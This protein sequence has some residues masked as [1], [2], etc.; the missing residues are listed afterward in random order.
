[1]SVLCVFFSQFHTKKGNQIDYQIPK[2]YIKKEDFD[3]ISE[4]ILPKIELCNKIISMKLGNAYLMGLPINISSPKYFRAKYQFNFCILITS[5]EYIKYREQY[6]NLLKIITKTYEE[7][8]TL[9]G[10]GLMIN[11]K[12][13]IFK[14]TKKLF[15]QLLN[16]AKIINIPIKLKILINKDE[17]KL[18]LEKFNDGHL[19]QDNNNDEENDK[20]TDDNI[21]SIKSVQNNDI[22]FKDNSLDKIDIKDINENKIK[23]NKNQYDNNN[24]QIDSNLMVENSKSRINPILM[25]NEKNIKNSD[26]DIDK[27]NE[28]NNENFQQDIITNNVLSKNELKEEN[29]IKDYN[30]K[31]SNCNN[32]TNKIL[33]NL[34]DYNPKSIKLI[35]QDY[36][37]D[38]LLYHNSDSIEVDFRFNMFKNISNKFIEIKD[39]Y[40][41]VFI[42]KIDEDSLKSLDPLTHMIYNTIDSESFVKKILIKIDIDLEYIKDVRSIIQNLAL[43]NVIALVDIFQYSNIYRYTK[44]P[45]EYYVNYEDFYKDFQY[46]YILNTNKNQEEIKNVLRIFNEELDA[47]TFFNL[48]SLLTNSECVEEFFKKHF[49]YDLNIKLFVAYGVYKE[50]INRTHLYYIVSNDNSQKSNVSDLCKSIMSLCDGNHS[51]DDICC[52]LWISLKDFKTHISLLEH[53]CIY[54]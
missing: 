50:L 8:E 26:I 23:T 45:L 5:E 54:K 14:F 15:F 27:Y 17:N 24:N 29:N 41:P 1:M 32:I 33:S 51:I 42:S 12:D 53:H 30:D 10:Y 16:N 9:F 20:E 21:N 13:N 49:F 34:K 43:V 4:F 18:K 28:Y 11:N 25:N 31:S 36:L 19:T 7:I 46:F 6:E 52:N 40:V 3:K 2:N 39:H 35:N 38:V 37:K 47:D 22:N 48:Y 44:N